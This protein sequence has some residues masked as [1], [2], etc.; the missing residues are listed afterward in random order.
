MEDDCLLTLSEAADQLG[1]NQKTVYRWVK[2][3]VLDVIPLPSGKRPSYRIRES[4]IATMIMVADRTGQNITSR[5]NVQIYRV[6]PC[7]GKMHR[8]MWMC[9]VEEVR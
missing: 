1:V 3:G 8:T 5:G 4:M 7:Y 2:S 9:S 6:S